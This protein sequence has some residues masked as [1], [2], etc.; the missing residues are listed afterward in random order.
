MIIAVPTFAG[1][2]VAVRL[3]MQVLSDVVNDVHFAHSGRVYVV[4]HN[5]RIVAHTDPRFV[6]NNTNIGRRPEFVAALQAPDQTWTGHYV[7]FE[8]LPVVGQYAPLPGTDWLVVTEVETAETHA[9]ARAAFTLLGGIMVL[10]AVLIIG[11]TLNR[12]DKTL[13]GPIKRLRDGVLR[14][15]RGDL[16]F[17]IDVVNTN[18]IGQ[19]A[20]AFNQMAANL[21]KHEQ[22]LLSRSDELAIEIAERKRTEEKIAAT[23][24]RLAYLVISSP[25]VIHSN[26]PEAGYPTS[27]VSDNV[28]DLTGYQAQDF[29]VDPQFWFKHIHPDDQPRVLA[30]LDRLMATGRLVASYRFHC[31]DDRDL[32]IRNEMRLVYN[33]EKR[34][35]EIV[36]SW[37]DITEQTLATEELAQARDQALEA[38]RLKSEFL[39]TMSH[40]IRTPMNGVIGMADLLQTTPL[41]DEQREYVEIIT[42]S[43]N[44]LLAIINDIL[45]LSKVEAG[46]L[47][48]VVK[49]FSFSPLSMTC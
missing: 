35:L 47:T 38:S 37:I 19:V 48:L 24:A 25:A 44:S 39:A 21:H 18:E 40:E 22:E 17:H 16:D 15:G 5:G 11:I 30:A 8:D 36:G 12:L 28:I 33:E 31:Q 3:E 1:G 4:D 27:F 10:F 14:I 9:V 34:P 13:F 23:Q 41:D 26:L 6:L 42:S 29:Y 2:V 7:N 32:W 43:G 20:T 46:K 49:E 45:D